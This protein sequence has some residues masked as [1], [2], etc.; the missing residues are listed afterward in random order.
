MH[1]IIRGIFSAIFLNWLF[2]FAKTIDPLLPIDHSQINYEKFEKNFYEEH[3]E[4]QSLSASEI[5]SLREA[6]GK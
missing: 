1:Y 4:I 3:E 2:N 6:L 5:D